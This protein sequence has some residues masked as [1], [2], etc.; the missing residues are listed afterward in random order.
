M[1]SLFNRQHNDEIIARLNVLSPEAKSEWGKMSVAQMLAH[2]QQ[3]LRVV[4]GELKLKRSLMGILFGSIAKKKLSGEEHWQHDMPT[5]K[6]FIIGEERI[7]ME[8]KQK[9][10]A[11]VRRLAELGPAGISVDVHPF[12]GKLTVN[13]WDRLMWNHVDHHLR[14]FGA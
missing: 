9:L 10:T 8:E 3:P 2:A 7:F 14:Q 5:D 1:K 6:N 11:L 4:F 13:E 12:F